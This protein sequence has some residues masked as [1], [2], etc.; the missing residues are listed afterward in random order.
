MKQETQELNT[1]FTLYQKLVIL[2][3]ALLQFVVILDFMIIAPIGDMLMKTL[4]I[5]T[6]QFGLV[7]SSYAFSAAIS[8]IAIAG[9]ADRYDRKKMLL[10]FVLG[11]MVGTFF[12]GLA[13]TYIELL[14][15]RIV[16]GIFAGV[17]SSTL[18]AIVADVFAAKLRGRVMGMVQMGFGLSQVLGIPLGIFIATRFNWH[19]TF[20]FIVA[21]TAL[22]L[23]AIAYG[24]KP[25]NEHLQ[26]QHDK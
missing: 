25:I 10:V 16:T 13:N 11:F 1:S 8:G 22:I 4:N 19:S 24:F 12:C 15:S 14:A 2:V 9:F 17:T 6:E 23:I 21:F 20:M 5:S 3:L 18:L 7:V 26:H